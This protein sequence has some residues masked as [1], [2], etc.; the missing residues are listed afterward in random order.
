MLFESISLWRSSSYQ[1]GVSLLAHSIKHLVVR[2]K[3]QHMYHYLSYLREHIIMTSPIYVISLKYFYV[4]CLLFFAYLTNIWSLSN[5]FFQVSMIAYNHLLYI[6]L[7]MLWINVNTISKLFV[8]R[9]RVS[10][11]QKGCI[12]L[13]ITS[14]FSKTTIF[15]VFNY[16]M[17]PKCH[18]R[19]SFNTDR[20]IFFCL[21]SFLGCRTSGMSEILV[22][23][24]VQLLT[25]E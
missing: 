6:C 2:A 19:S 17:K 21:L 18:R 16:I 1:W 11:K 5:W 15:L 14:A 12:L 9:Q 20:W 24:G 8:F 23:R 22:M 10:W 7:Y 4:Y 25:S 3:P 13:E